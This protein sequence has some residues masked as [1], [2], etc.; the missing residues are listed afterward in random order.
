MY[1]E[2]L[3]RKKKEYGESW[4]FYT[5]RVNIYREIKK[6]KNTQTILVFL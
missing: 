3:I 5:D 4:G 6:K 2:V 1:N